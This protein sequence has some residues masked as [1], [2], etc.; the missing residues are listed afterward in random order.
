MC[1]IIGKLASIDRT[2]PVPGIKKCFC[3]G[4][5][6]AGWNEISNGGD[7]LPGNSGLNASEACIECGACSEEEFLESDEYDDIK[8]DLENDALVKAITIPL[9][10][11]LIIY[12]IYKWVKTFYGKFHFHGVYQHSFD[13]NP[14]F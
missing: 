7:F 13:K 12:C 14:I 9:A 2:R 10:I 5:Y 8:Q 4:N 11:C 6:G 1:K 3:S